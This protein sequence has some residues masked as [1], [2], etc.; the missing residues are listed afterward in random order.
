MILYICCFFVIL[1]WVG[2]GILKYKNYKLDCK[3]LELE[4]KVKELL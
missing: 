3:I 4:K 2:V 1:V